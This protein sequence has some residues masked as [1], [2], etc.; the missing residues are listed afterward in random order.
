MDTKTPRP[1][2]RIGGVIG[3]LKFKDIGERHWNW[4]HK[5]ARR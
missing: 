1:A 5:D 4:R 3:G 2:T